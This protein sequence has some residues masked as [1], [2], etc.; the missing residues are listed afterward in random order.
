VSATVGH[1]NTRRQEELEDKQIKMAFYCPPDPDH[2]KHDT[3]M[4]DLS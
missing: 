1:K 2:S 4:K 3:D